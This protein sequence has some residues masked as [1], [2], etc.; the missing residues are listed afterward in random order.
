MISYMLVGMK[1]EV[2]ILNPDEPDSHKLARAGRILDECGLV[3]FPTET[4][5]GIGCAAVPDAIARL[6]EVKR[7]AADK[8]YTL[9][10]AS[11][12]KVAEYVPTIPRRAAKLIEKGW[13]GP[14]TVVF[15]LEARQI[16]KQHNMMDKGVFSVLYQGNTIGIR[17]PAGPVARELLGFAT[18]AVVA[19]SANLHSMPPATNAQQVL[20][21]FDGR[22]DMIL[23]GGACKYK[24]SSTV[25]KMSSDGGLEILRDGVYSE[26]EVAEMSLIRIL[27]VC[28]GNTCRSPMAEA[29]CRKY[30]S[31]KFGCAIDKLEQIGYKVASVG[32]IPYEGMPASPEVVAICAEKNVDISSHRSRV[33]ACAE[34][35]ESD[36]IFVMTHSHRMRVLEL[37]P[38]VADKCLLLDD[39]TEIED[40]IGGS[41]EVYRRCAERIDKTLNKR[42]SEILR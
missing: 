36:Y 35:C 22:I 41:Q 33:L 16:E 42:M 12:D 3:A 34:A 38:G 1:T 14:L 2:V 25:V 29:L 21:Q 5:Y 31:E 26:D 24:K 6:D 40:P 13:P 11:K 28:T 15:E 20:E 37:C 32:V 18:A 10:I 7:R 39:S 9:H 17:C 27:F 4:V 19:P 23:D 8:C 30:I